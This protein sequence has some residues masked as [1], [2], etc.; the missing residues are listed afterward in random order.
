M[1]ILKPSMAGIAAVLLVIGMASCYVVKSDSK[2]EHPTRVEVSNLNQAEMAKTEVDKLILERKG[3]QT[4]ID[5][6][7]Y[8]LEKIDR[9]IQRAA[10]AQDEYLLRIAFAEQRERQEL[11]KNDLLVRDRLDAEIARAK[12]DMEAG[13]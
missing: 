7:A 9:I 11:V 13:K 12:V 4:Y 8:E 5:Y 10:A 2:A 6:R 3:I 1:K